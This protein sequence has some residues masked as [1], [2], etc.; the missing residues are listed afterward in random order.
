MKPSIAWWLDIPV[1]AAPHRPS[2]YHRRPGTSRLRLT[3]WSGVKKRARAL[4]REGGPPVV[5]KE[6]EL[7]L[8]ASVF[9]SAA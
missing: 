6:P 4:R 1:N 2:R 5:V 8:N 7:Y 3:E 9:R